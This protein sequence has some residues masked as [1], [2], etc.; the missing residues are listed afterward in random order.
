MG[1]NSKVHFLTAYTEYLFD[2]G[3]KSEYYYLGD[4]S[5]FMRFL[6]EQATEEDL[7][8]FLATSASRS[9]YEKRLRK[10]LKKFYQFAAERL[11]ISTDLLSRL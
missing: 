11:N 7:Q 2:Q 4:A 5:R 9:N 1:K 10:T 6:L 3:I 8:K